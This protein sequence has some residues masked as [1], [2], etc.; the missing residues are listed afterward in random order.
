MQ[1][2]QAGYDDYLAGDDRTEEMQFEGGT[3][4]VNEYNCGRRMA[5]EDCDES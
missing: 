3:V 5:R 4:A 2:W 1:Y